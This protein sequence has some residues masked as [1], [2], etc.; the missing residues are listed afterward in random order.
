MP[1]CANAGNWATVRRAHRYNLP[2][3][4]AGEDARAPLSS[5]SFAKGEPFGQARRQAG[6]ENFL[7]GGGDIVIEA[8]QFDRA[9]VHVVNDIGGLWDCYR[10]A[11]RRLPTLTKYFLPGSTLNFE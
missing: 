9:F 10:A 1:A 2:K 4:A 5:A 11:G 8:A 3:L 6:I 7:L